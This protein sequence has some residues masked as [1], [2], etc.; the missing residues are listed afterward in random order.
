MVKRP[1]AET[2]AELKYNSS[3][4]QQQKAARRDAALEVATAA[5]RAITAGGLRVEDQASLD[6]HTKF[7]GAN[8]VVIRAVHIK[9]P[10]SGTDTSVYVTRTG[11]IWVGKTADDAT[12]IPLTYCAALDRLVYEGPDEV[13]SSHGTKAKAKATAVDLIAQA[14]ADKRF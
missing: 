4:E 12:E 10:A 9:P 14:I 3:P 8:V 1:A 13:E 7:G 5:A 11:G 6:V 2:L